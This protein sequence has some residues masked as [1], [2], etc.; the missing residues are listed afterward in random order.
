MARFIGDQN[1]VVILFESGTYGSTSGTGIWPGQVAESI[2]DDNEG[3]IEERYLGTLTRNF[4]Q[5]DQGPRDVTGKLTYAPQDMRLVFWAIGSVVDT[6]GTNFSHRVS[7]INT[8]VRQNGYTSGT[9]NPPMSFTIEDSKQSTGTGRNFIRT[10][11]GCIPNVTVLDLKPKERASVEMDYIGQT[12]T[13]SSGTTTT[14]AEVVN[15]PYLWSSATL[16]LNGSS[17]TTVKGIKLKIDQKTE[18]PHYLNG[19]RDI[20]VP[21]QKNRFVTL[22]ADL[23][24][25]GNDADMLYNTLYKNN[26]SFNGILDLNQDN[27][28][29]GSQHT[30]FTLSGCRIMR[31]DA[32][33]KDDGVNESKVEINVQSITA[34]SWDRIG[35]YNPW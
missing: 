5:I 30:A 1:K 21:F 4:N 6:S 32:P 27:A 8:D 18:A 20:S 3:K 11:N 17:I 28:T 14:V 13:Y 7:L 9:L 2:I 16:Q 31:M 25:D 22:D 12:L 15:K 10:V 34:N 35:S 23:D 33:S 19:S 26:G 29:A 24:L